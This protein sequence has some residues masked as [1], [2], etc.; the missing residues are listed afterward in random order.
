MV[1]SDSGLFFSGDVGVLATSAIYSLVPKE[2]ND[3]KKKDTA[4]KMV[5]ILAIEPQV[6]VSI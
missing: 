5:L 3:R 2:S 6:W 4:C 1:N